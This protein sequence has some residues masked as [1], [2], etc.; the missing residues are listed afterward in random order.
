MKLDCATTNWSKLHFYRYVFIF[1]RSFVVHSS[2][3]FL[4][5]TRLFR[6]D[7]ATFN[8]DLLL[9]DSNLFTQIRYSLIIWHNITRGLF[10]GGVFRK[11]GDE[12]L[13]DAFTFAIDWI[14]THANN[15]SSIFPDRIDY[16]IHLVDEMNLYGVTRNGI[17]YLIGVGLINFQFV[18]CLWTIM[19]RCCLAAHIDHCTRISSIYRAWCMCHWWVSAKTFASTQLWLESAKTNHQ[20]VIIIIEHRHRLHWASI[21]IRAGSWST[22]SPIWFVIGDGTSW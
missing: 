19:Y 20:K 21:C 4:V 13:I 14:N 5:P 11:V 1:C 8:I 3:S 10:W 6:P 2:S 12:H 18:K 9:T 7:A 17:R 16:S 22:R 15:M